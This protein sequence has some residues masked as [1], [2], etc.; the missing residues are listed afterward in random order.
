MK[1]LLLSLSVLGLIAGTAGAQSLVIVE[2]ESDTMAMG[3][4]HTT[5][6]IESHVV[7]QNV[8]NYAMDVMVKRLDVNYNALTDSN[9]I[10]WGICFSTDV[11]VSP[12][13]TEKTLQPG[14][15]S[16]MA[17]FVGHVYPD[18]D[19]IPLA[20]DITYVFFDMNNPND[21]VAHTVRYEVTSN[22][23]QPEIKKREV[24]DLYP[25]PARQRINLNY[26][27]TGYSSA[28]IELI[29]LV[30]SRVFFRELPTRQDE[31]RLDVSALPRGV[32]FYNLRADGKALRSRKLVLE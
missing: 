11:S 12:P 14:E 31:L 24:L 18:M 25:N 29:N 7:I 5:H 16:G 4:A 19:G 21:S 6:D 26:D 30:G 3:N 20:G 2:Q 13:G 15:K 10:C 8:G 22:F 27:L 32:Y 9:A 28:S 17:D 23:D 1:R